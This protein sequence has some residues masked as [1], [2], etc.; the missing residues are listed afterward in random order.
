MNKMSHEDEVLEAK[1]V[2][3]DKRQA[4]VF[5]WILVAMRLVIPLSVIYAIYLYWTLPPSAYL[6]GGY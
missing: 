1:I 2:D 3:R 4:A 6:A 5:W